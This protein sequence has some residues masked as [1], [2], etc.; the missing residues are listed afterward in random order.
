MKTV[1]RKKVHGR[2]TVLVKDV[3]FYPM[4]IVENFLKIK[5]PIFSGKYYLPLRL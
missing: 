1:Q 5:I 2:L 3:K 4:L